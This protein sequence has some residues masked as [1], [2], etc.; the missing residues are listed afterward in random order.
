MLLFA[1]VGN[2]FLLII[3][4]N[5]RSYTETMIRSAI[6]LT[7]F[8]MYGD[9]PKRGFLTTAVVVSDEAMQQSRVVFFYCE[10]KQIWVI[11][12]KVC[13]SLWSSDII[14]VMVYGSKPLPESVLTTVINIICNI[15]TWPGAHKVVIFTTLL[16]CCCYCMMYFIGW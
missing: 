12:R 14:G 9:N 13:D 10:S 5:W 3:C 2:R 15:L 16:C 11:S 8:F 4:L 7:W 1:C 6:N